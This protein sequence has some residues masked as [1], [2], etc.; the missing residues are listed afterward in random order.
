[1]NVI[2]KKH[3]ARRTF[4]RAAGTAIALPLLDAMLPA[5]TPMAKAATSVRRFV[6]VWHPHGAAPGYW[7]PT[8]AGSDFEFSYITKPLEPFR[9]RVVLITGLDVPEAF[10]TEEEPG[11]NHARG[12]VFLS[13]AR[14]RRN[15]VSP[16]LGVTIDQLIADRYGQ[17]TI[18]SSVQ[19]GVEDAGNYGNCNWGYSCA[20]TNSIS[21]R[22]PT[23][24]L[25]T[26]IN[27]HVAFE[28][29]FGTGG[30]AQERRQGRL[31]KAS[32][33]DSVAQEIPALKQSLSK[34]DQGRLDS[35][36]ENIRELE[37]RLR[38]A[39]DKSAAEPDATVPFGIPQSKDEHLK[40][41]F[42]LIA[43]AFQGDITRSATMMFGVDISSATFPESGTNGAW[44]GTSHH[45]DKP[46]N[47]AE[48]ALM[49]RY[50]V[51]ILARF[52][53]KLRAI[54]DV[55]GNALDNSLVYMG[56]NMGNS[57][58]HAHEK[59][60]VILAG[61]IDGTF[62]GNR[63]LVFPDNTERASNML[64]SLLH[65]YGIDRASIGQSTGALPIT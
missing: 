17:D 20:Y 12:A 58:R 4:L 9:D 52:L 29:L 11:G 64:L 16:Y 42:D 39:L 60:P 62:R 13:G 65:L 47:I 19:L 40:L 54:E 30:T 63:H 41:M 10:S 50:H 27:P 43:L 56:S 35:Y 57:H 7:S 46:S 23:Q 36:F 26:E 3:L 53:D 31:R 25:P 38:I 24:P 55:D 14:P 28:R 61:G 37:R 51:S 8:Q 6:G 44:H 33:L 21:W 22:G 15:A 34:E 32:L 1:M 18:V 59:V 5:L 2:R 49:N 48:Y 45:G